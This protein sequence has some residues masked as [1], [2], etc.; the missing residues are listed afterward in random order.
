MMCPYRTVFA[1][2]RFI[3][4]PLNISFWSINFSF[5]GRPT[6]N[7]RHSSSLVTHGDTILTKHTHTHCIIHHVGKK[8][9]TALPCFTKRMATP[10]FPIAIQKTRNWDHG[11]RTLLVGSSVLTVACLLV[12]VTVWSVVRA[13]ILSLFVLWVVLDVRYWMLVAWWMLAW[14]TAARAI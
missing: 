11:V 3:L 10:M 5:V 6:L 14:L 9:T 1:F 4:I 8:C 13:H 7:L 2:L 12:H